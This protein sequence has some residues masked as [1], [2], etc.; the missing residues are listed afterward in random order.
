MI[1]GFG[2]VWIGFWKVLK[3]EKRRK[4]A[5]ARLGRGPV[6]GRR[7]PSLKKMEEALPGGRAAAWPC[8]AAALKGKIAQKCVFVMET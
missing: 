8:R 6:L 2:D 3:V 4:V 5:G 7:G 1:F